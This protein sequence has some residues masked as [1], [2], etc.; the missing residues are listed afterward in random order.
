MLEGASHGSLGPAQPLAPEG[1]PRKDRLLPDLGVDCPGDGDPR[2]GRDPARQV[3][4]LGQGFGSPAADPCQQVAADDDPVAPEFAQA[5]ERPAASLQ[6]A[7]QRLLV[8]LGT[9]QVRGVR[10][11]DPPS[12]GHRRSTRLDVAHHR[13]Q[14]R[15]LDPGIGIEDDDDIAPTVLRRDGGERRS[16]AVGQLVP[17]TPH[18]PDEPG[19]ALLRGGGAGDPAVPSVERSSTTTTSNSGVPSGPRRSWAARS[20]TRRPIT[21]A[22]SRA[23]TTTVAERDPATTAMPGVTAASPG[24]MGGRRPAMAIGSAAPA[25]TAARPMTRLRAG[26]GRVAASPR[27]IPPASVPSAAHRHAMGVAGRAPGPV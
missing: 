3:Q 27:T 24:W 21:R 20:P 12:G 8:G 19:D 9:G 4:V 26:P 5:T 22:S 10:V 11:E 6:L 16:L 15:R 25:A 17:F 23:A 2:L 1:G 13:P 14:E 7:V 18:D